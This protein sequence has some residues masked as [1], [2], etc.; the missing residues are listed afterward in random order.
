VAVIAA[1]EAAAPARSALVRLLLVAACVAALFAAWQLQEVTVIALL[2]LGIAVLVAAWVDRRASWN[3]RRHGGRL[4]FGLTGLL[5]V[6]GIAWFFSRSGSRFMSASL[7]AADRALEPQFYLIRGAG[8]L[9]LLWPLAPVLT[10]MALLR[11]NRPVIFAAAFFVVCLVFH[12]IAAQKALRYFFYA[13]PFLCAVLGCGIAAAVHYGLRY[14]RAQGWNTGRQR[15]SA[16]VM[17]A[18][19]TILMSQEGQRTLKWM[20]GELQPFDNAEYELD[21][22]A[23]VQ[24]LESEIR[25]HHVLV[26][27]NSMK[28]LYFIGDYDVEFNP[29]VVP[30]TRSGE[31]FGM[32]YRTGRPV[33]GTVGSLAR[34]TGGAERVLVLVERRKVASPFFAHTGI[35]EWLDGNC[36]EIQMS[37]TGPLRAWTCN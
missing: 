35:V 17:L 12:S 2:G 23:A 16:V 13:W 21:W 8:Q 3:L 30:E 4:A 31:E 18:A 7:W 19:I 32:D 26:T 10:A 9:P 22:T 37:A 11:W 6:V 36:L 33:I 28:A 5:V 20:S 25:E 15:A 1:F 29:S 14:L 34:V 24:S 27:S